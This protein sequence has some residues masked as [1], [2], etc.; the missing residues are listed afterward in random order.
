STWAIN[1]WSDHVYTTSTYT[2]TLSG[3]KNMVLEYYENGGINRV[4]F[5]MTSTLL[6]VTLTSWT[7][8]S[9]SDDLALLKW[10]FTDAVNFDHFVVQRSTDGQNFQDVQ[11]LPSATTQYTD[12]FAYNGTV[13]YRLKMVDI[14]GQTNYSGIASLVRHSNTTSRIY[15]TV[16]E[17]NTIY[18]ETA[19]TIRQPRVEL[20]DMNGRR[21]LEKEWPG[22]EGRQQMTLPSLPAGA[23]LVRLSDLQGALT[24]QIIMIR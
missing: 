22:L 2:A 16:V 21:L 20:F 7:A 14:D 10:T 23:Y 19:K 24:K 13:Y 18:V 6:P 12:L 15:P 5:T 3:T 4:S 1:N 9:Q 11:S 17:N 8:T